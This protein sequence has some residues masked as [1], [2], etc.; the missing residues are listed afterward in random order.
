MTPTQK[1]FA[2]CASLAVLLGLLDLVRRRKLKEEYA[3]LWILTGVGMLALTLWYSLLE[4]MTRLIGAVTVTTT[5]FIFGLLFLL[6]I[7]MHFSTVISRLTE[8]VRR[9][10][11]ELAILAAE[12]Q[13]PRRDGNPQ[14]PAP[15]QPERPGAP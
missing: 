12:Q 14:T 4:W 3:W 7:S 9:L 10:A 1:V 13:E 2:V 15:K 11:Q 6:L 5:L 8:D